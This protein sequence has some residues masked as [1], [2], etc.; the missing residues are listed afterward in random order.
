MDIKLTKQEYEA[1]DSRSLVLPDTKL[2]TFYNN[3]PISLHDKAKKSRSGLI[4]SLR[5]SL[6]GDKIIH[7]R[8]VY[9]VL[10]LFSDLGGVLEIFM[11]LIGLLLYPF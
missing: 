5:I 9:N 2:G 3:S 1:Y 11:V 8:N 10:D 4:F 7:T 6:D